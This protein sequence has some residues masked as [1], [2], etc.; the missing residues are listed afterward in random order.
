MASVFKRGKTYHAAF[1]AAD[2]KWRSRSTRTG[3]KAV[4]ERIARKW[5]ADAALRRDGVIDP[6]MESMANAGKR[7]I[8]EHLAEYESHLRSKGNSA[9]YLKQAPAMIRKAIDAC[10]WK[11]IADVS[12]ARFTQ[13]LNGMKAAG[14][15]ARTVNAHRMAVRGFTRWLTIE[16]R[17]KADPLLNVPKLNEAT[18]RKRIRRA[19]SDQEIALLIDAA[20]ASGVERFGLDGKARAMLYRTALGTGFRLNELQSLTPRSFNLYGE[21]PT[22]TVEAGY[23]KRRRRDVQP[24]RSDLAET[25]AP[26]LE[27][28]DSDAR[29]WHAGHDARAAKMI[30]AD[31]RGARMVWIRSAGADWQARQE[32]RESCFLRAADAAGRVADFHALRHTF[33]TRLAR[34]GVPAV[35]A[36]NLARHSTITLTMDRYSHVGLVDEL[37][38]LNALPAVAVQA[39][40]VVLAATGT[41]DQ[42]TSPNDPVK[43]VAAHLQRAQAP[44][45]QPM[46]SSAIIGKVRTRIAQTPTIEGFG[47]CP[48]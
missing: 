3:D 20:E 42:A 14:K 29:P 8:A 39:E 41:D 18:D 48:P 19:L 33:I 22:I 34:A 26:W 25:L 5:E 27:R 46:P 10:G 1:I 23:S 38:A 30:A 28:F 43:R 24:I 45:G 4:A 47:R 7:A 36:K 2:G 44:T 9:D 13:H 15:S 17:I 11:A 40:P 32:R 12:A 35:V 21:P 37:A 16:A 31:L 6:T